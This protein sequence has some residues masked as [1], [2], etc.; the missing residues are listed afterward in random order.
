MK[1]E[2]DEATKTVSKR[3]PKPMPMAR[4]VAAMS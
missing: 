2:M 3:R 4:R 1:G